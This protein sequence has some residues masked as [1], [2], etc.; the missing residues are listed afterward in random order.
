M[1]HEEFLKRIRECIVSAGETLISEAD[2][3]VG[4]VSDQLGVSDFQILINLPSAGDIESI[5]PTICV[6]TTYISQDLVKKLY[7]H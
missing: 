2:D 5:C 4:E 7:G 6:S 3:L 1:N